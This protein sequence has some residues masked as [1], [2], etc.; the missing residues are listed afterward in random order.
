[1]RRY[2][3]LVL[4][5]ALAILLGPHRQPAAQV[6][7]LKELYQDAGND[8]SWPYDE[9]EADL[10]VRYEEV[11]NSIE[12]VPGIRGKAFKFNGYDSFIYLDNVRETPF[13]ETG[14]TVSFVAKPFDF[15]DGRRQAF[16]SNL[17]APGNWWNAVSMSGATV[18]LALKNKLFGESFF[19]RTGPALAENEFA[20]VIVVYKN[21]GRQESSVKI[22]I[23]GRKCELSCG[24]EENSPPFSKNFRPGYNPFAR[25][26]LVLGRL[27]DDTPRA[28]FE[29]VMDSVSIYTEA[30]DD[31]DVLELIKSKIQR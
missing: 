8:S 20:H 13:P 5:P 19:W 12:F 7:Q 11:F 25:E 4:I 18:E 3:L 28:Y 24:R 31:F 30:L 10:F 1:M 15:R 2:V 27:N 29:G 23:N 21:T 14:F 16:I 9:L 17:Q 22:Y 26:G 6:D